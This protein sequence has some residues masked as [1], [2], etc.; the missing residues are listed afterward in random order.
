MYTYLHIICRFTQF[1][2]MAEIVAIGD[3][4][5]IL[6]LITRNIDN[7]TTRSEDVNS[8]LQRILLL[9]ILLKELDGNK[10][11]G[12][13]IQVQKLLCL[14]REFQSWVENYKRKNAIFHFFKAIINKRDITRF[15]ERINEIQNSI[16]FELGIS[17][18]QIFTEVNRNTMKLVQSFDTPTSQNIDKIERLEI[19]I[20]QQQ[21]R[22]QELENIVMRLKP[23]ETQSIE[24]QTVSEFNGE[25]VQKS[26]RAK[27]ESQRT[28]PICLR[29]KI[30]SNTMYLRVKK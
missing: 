1:K 6:K 22:I 29:P 8:L 7:Y 17:N 27:S 23:I 26:K 19:M 15:H 28:E 20:H 5:G 30:I 12:V 4:L 16:R 24:I 11:V 9:D 10:S 13:N 2:S 3:V 18:N 14:V 21:M 25:M